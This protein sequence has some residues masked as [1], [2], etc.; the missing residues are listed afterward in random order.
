MNGQGREAGVFFLPFVVKMSKM[1]PF[2]FSIPHA[3]KDKISWVNLLGIWIC[4]ARLIDV[5]SG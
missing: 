2:Y 3:F 4:F 5:S 1:F